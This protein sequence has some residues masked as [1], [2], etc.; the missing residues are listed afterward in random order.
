MWET[1]QLREVI[2]PEANKGHEKDGEFPDLERIRSLV[3][4]TLI[5]LSNYRSPVL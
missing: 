5:V 3:F 4:D 1:R 2:Q